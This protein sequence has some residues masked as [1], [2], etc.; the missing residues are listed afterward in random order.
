MIREKNPTLLE[1]IGDFDNEKWMQDKAER[2][3]ATVGNLTG[4][5][6]PKCK[7]KGVVLAVVDGEL[8]MRMCECDKARKSLK[9][10]EESGLKPLLD[11]YTFERYKAIDPWQKAA[12]SMSQNFL[13]YGE[14]NWLFFG[15]QSGSGKSHLC[16]AICGQ[17]LKR[18]RAVK[19][20][21]WK[22]DATKL[23]TIITDTQAYTKLIDEIK[24]VDVLYIDDFLKVQRG[25]QPTEADVLL[26]FEILN[27]R[28]VNKSFTLISSE[29]TIDE[30]IAIDD[31]LGGRIYQMAKNYSMNIAYDRNKN[32]RL[33]K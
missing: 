7:N 5:D 25:K 33:R 29:K 1:T 28:Y 23:K 3:N 6:C 18:G 31:A 20:M 8:K 2:E 26:A 11:E 15:G 12:L 16:T 4:V 9:R 17:L 19:Y 22:D 13:E 10:L 21:M 14:G 27:H 32:Y 30:I 24:S